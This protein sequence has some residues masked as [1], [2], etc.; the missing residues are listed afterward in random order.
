MDQ[1]S[2]TT[3]DN[4]KKKQEV[5]QSEART[6][7]SSKPVKSTELDPLQAIDA[8]WKEESAARSQDSSQHQ[9]HTAS[10]LPDIPQGTA[11][12]VEGQ[13]AL[14][15]KQPVKT[16]Q[17]QHKAKKAKAPPPDLPSLEAEETQLF[18]EQLQHKYPSNDTVQ[19][20]ALVDHLLM[21]FKHVTQ[22]SF[23]QVSG[24]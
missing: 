12:D 5:R 11:V 19:L 22:T 7:Q 3:V 23:D 20:Q 14:P 15:G 4:R 16:K 2:W 21:K 13:A 24:P 17:R 1:D 10:S 8:S 6:A 9:A 18:L